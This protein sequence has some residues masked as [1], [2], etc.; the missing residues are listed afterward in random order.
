MLSNTEQ[1]ERISRLIALAGTLLV[2]GLLV[3]GLIFISF[4]SSL[5][6]P[7]EEGVD[8]YLDQTDMLPVNTT[9]PPVL[10]DSPPAQVG[11]G[12]RYIIK[13]KKETKKRKRANRKPRKTV[14][15]KHSKRTTVVETPQEIIVNP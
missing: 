3:A 12:D 10:S 11:A 7:A 5:P 9:V 13:K 15:V 1:K 6:L 4:R 14:P 2:H 8:V